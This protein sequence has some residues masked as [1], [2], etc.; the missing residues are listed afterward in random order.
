[1]ESKLDSRST[2]LAN[3]RFKVSEDSTGGEA[4]TLISHLAIVGHPLV[5]VPLVSSRTP[6][7]WKILEPSSFTVTKLVAKDV[8]EK[9][10]NK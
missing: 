9:E 3:K 5:T 1:M 7:R 10:I 2:L 4:Q 6:L 8:Q